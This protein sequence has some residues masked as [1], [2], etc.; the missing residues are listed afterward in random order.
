[1][2]NMIDSRGSALIVS[3]LLMMVLSMMMI[4]LLERILPASRTT[5]WI[6]NSV[7]ALYSAGSATENM[8]TY[9]RQDNPGGINWTQNIILPSSGQS[10]ASGSRIIDAANILPAPGN[11]NSEGDSN[12]SAIWPR[13][14]VQLQLN[15]IMLGKWEGLRIE[16]RMPQFGSNDIKAGDTNATR[17]E[18]IPDPIIG[19]SLT[20]G[21]TWIAIDDGCIPPD[22]KGFTTAYINTVNPPKQTLGEM[23]VKVIGWAPQTLTA[24]LTAN[25]SFCD[26]NCTLKFSVLR[27]LKNAAWEVLPYIEYRIRGKGTIPAGK[28][29]ECLTGYKG[30]TAGN[31]CTPDF[32]LP[33]L[34]PLQTATI[35]SEWQKWGFKKTI[36]RTYDQL[37]TSEGLDFT[38]FQ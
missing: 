3:I 30:N 33:S 34:Y 36:T 6:E 18:N 32:Y 21:T 24:Y 35:I 8:L 7:Q 27:S 22:K 28:T 37:T 1:M 29:E 10:T 23:C 26:N 31:T 14:A 25:N 16:F 2:S 9:L 20:N 5:K 13:R 4:F 12:W 38:V 15:S 19:F 17:P 11:G